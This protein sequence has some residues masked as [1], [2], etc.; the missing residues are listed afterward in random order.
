MRPFALKSLFV[1]SIATLG[2]ALSS[3]T[4]WTEQ[5]LTALVVANT[6]AQLQTA[7]DSFISPNVALELNGAN[8][9]LAGFTA[10]LQAGL[11]NRVSANVTFNAV[12]E[13]PSNPQSPAAAGWVGIFFV[14]NFVYG[15]PPVNLTVEVASDLLL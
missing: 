8:I 6:T 3:L 4:E 15:N 10:F 1:L 13:V 14:T 7:I 5:H 9:T 2:H 11:P 12:V